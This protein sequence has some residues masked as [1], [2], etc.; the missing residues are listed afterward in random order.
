MVEEWQAGG[1]VA[2][3][4]CVNIDVDCRVCGAAGAAV[5]ITDTHVHR[6]K[7]VEFAQ[8]R[9]LRRVQ[10]NNRNLNNHV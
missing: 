1:M 9:F 10:A 3:G 5:A 2:G 8:I 7:H 6:H 4:D